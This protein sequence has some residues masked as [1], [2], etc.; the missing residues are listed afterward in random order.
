METLTN[1]VMR[2][3]END[4]G[5]QPDFGSISRIIDSMK[6]CIDDSNKLVRSAQ[7]ETD[8]VAQDL[9]EIESGVSPAPAS[10]GASEQ[11]RLLHK[12]A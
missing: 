5:D 7:N 1:K 3:F 2:D 4:N 12:R 11:A 10:G 9:A 6:F 8:R